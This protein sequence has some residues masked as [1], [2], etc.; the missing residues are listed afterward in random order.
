MKRLGRTLTVL[1]VTGLVMALFIPSA[2]AATECNGTFTGVTISGGV[3]VGPLD[4]CVL[5]DSVVAGGIHQTGGSL[6]VCGSMVAGG[7]HTTGGLNVT[8]GAGPDDGDVCMGNSISGGVKISGVLG[9][10]LGVG[11]A[12]IELELNT[13]NG[14]VFLDNNPTALVEVE[15]N[16]ING[17]LEC[18]GNLVVSNNG[19]PNTVTG[20]KSGQCASL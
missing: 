16:I 4:T 6:T 20:S 13:I 19:F 18:S 8:L 10:P 2:L 17:S 12:G 3:D 11:L 9:V 5:T 14:A 1:T 7:V 15:S